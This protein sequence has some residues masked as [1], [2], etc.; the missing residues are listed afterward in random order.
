MT[1]THCYNAAMSTHCL[2][3]EPHRASAALLSGN[4]RQGA[5]LLGGSSW[6]VFGDVSP[7]WQPRFDIAWLQFTSGVSHDPIESSPN[8]YEYCNDNPVVYVDPTGLLTFNVPKFTHNNIQRNLKTEKVPCPCPPG[9][10][11]TRVYGTIEADYAITVGVSDSYF[12]LFHDAINIV[13]GGAV[14]VGVYASWSGKQRSRTTSRSMWT[15]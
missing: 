11:G 1:A 2:R 4:S 3:A 12:K 14:D 5:T 8:L 10:Y 7:E 9:G 15:L 6:Q 13:T